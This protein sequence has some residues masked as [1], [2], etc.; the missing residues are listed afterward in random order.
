[1]LGPYVATVNAAG[2]AMPVLTN[3]FYLAIDGIFDWMDT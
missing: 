3:I 1:M 2:T